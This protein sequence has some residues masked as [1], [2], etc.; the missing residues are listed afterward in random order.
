MSIRGCLTIAH[1][2]VSVPA[3]GKMSLRSVISGEQGNVD[4]VYVVLE[5]LWAPFIHSYT[6]TAAS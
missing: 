1:K 6:L 4:E 2:G 5:A 3:V